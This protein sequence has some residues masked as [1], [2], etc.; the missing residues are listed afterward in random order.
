MNNII[1]YQCVKLSKP[2]VCS[3]GH[4]SP[5]AILPWTAIYYYSNKLLLITALLLI[6]CVTKEL[7]R[8]V[9]LCFVSR[10][11]LL[12]FKRSRGTDI[13]GKNTQNKQVVGHSRCWC[14][15][16]IKTSHSLLLLLLFI[17]HKGR[18]V[19]GALSWGS[20]GDGRLHPGQV[21]SLSQQHQTLRPTEN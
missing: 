9:R 12:G 3:N 15:F 10:S 16:Q 11:L 19:A 5:V 7:L 1:P 21:A 20:W 13:V 2:T 4:R 14:T 6:S 8:Q 18:W 17:L